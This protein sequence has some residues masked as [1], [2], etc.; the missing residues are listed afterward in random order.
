MRRQISI[1]DKANRNKTKYNILTFNAHERYQTQL[2]K[3]GHN[4][5][6]FNYEEGKDWYEGHGAM[7]EN[8]YQLG[9]NN[10]PNIVFDM[11]LSHSKF[12]QYQVARK[13]NDTL[14]IPLISLEHTLP[15]PQWPQETLSQ[16]LSM[17]GDYNIFITNY[18]K[19]KWG[20]DGDVIE[21]SVDTN[22]FKPDD[23]ADRS[24]ILTVAHDFI[25]RDYALNYQGWERITK[26]LDR[27]VVGETEGLSSQSKSVEDLIKAYQN[28]LVY[29]NPSVLSPVPT[30]MLE[31]MSCGCAI[32]TTETCSIPDF[33]E[34][35]VN[36]FISN[37][38]E[39]LRSYCEQLLEDKPLAARMGAEARKTIE[40]KFSEQEFITKW[41]NVFDRAYKGI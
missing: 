9:K 19:E 16:F 37:D 14:Q 2:A 5:Y 12:G 3:T 35:G 27:V 34:H 26:G 28:A 29:I 39:D 7:P 17:T 13:I 15:I 10:V 20:M 6:S 30:S 40:E 24:K 23:D 8:C 31:A 33:I 22:I 1:I 38:E 25:K 11:I 36:G 41:N 4:F 21:H 32:V 18:S